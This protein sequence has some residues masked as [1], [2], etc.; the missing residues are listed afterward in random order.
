MAMANND[1]S[2]LQ[3]FWDKSFGIPINPDEFSNVDYLSLAP[4]PV[5]VEALSLLKEKGRVLDYGCGEGWASIILAKLGCENVKSV[6]VSKNA[7]DRLKEM[8]AAFGVADR[9]DGETINSDWLLSQEGQ[10]D[11]FFSSNVIDVV[12][13]EIAK[14]II[15]GAYRATIP[16]AMVIFSLNFYRDPGEL[17]NRGFEI[18]DNYCYVDGVLRLNL[19]KDEEWLNQF[20]PYFDLVRL[21]YY[22]WPKEKTSTRRLFIL[23]R[24]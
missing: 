3:E 7:I 8:S 22:A 21:D 5:Q 11:G 15:E 13:L 17:K 12:P 16:G 20:A 6:D 14:K 1:Y 2:I 19:L 10:C 4:S 9:I 18:R 23:K 24:K